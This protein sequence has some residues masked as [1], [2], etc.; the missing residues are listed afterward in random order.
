MTRLAT[1]P[2]FTYVN[3]GILNRQVSTL[4]CHSLQNVGGGWFVPE[5]DFDLDQTTF[6]CKLPIL[7][8][9]VACNSLGSSY[10]NMIL[11]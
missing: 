1:K 2:P 9:S 6:K 7:R 5:A 10:L 11:I 8:A 3:L 4:T